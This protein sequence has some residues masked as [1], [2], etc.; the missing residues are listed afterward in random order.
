MARR[1]P[2]SSPASPK[3]LGPD[4]DFRPGSYW[5]GDSLR[6]AILGNIQGEARRRLLEQAL[7]AGD[8]DFPPEGLLRPI[9]EPGLRDLLGKIHPNFMGG[10]YLPDYLPEEVEIAR[11]AMNSTTGD[12][13]SIRANQEEDGLLHY[14]VVDEY[15]REFRLPLEVSDLPLSTGQMI[16]L[17]DGAE[18][19]DTGLILPFLEVNCEYDDAE[20]LRDFIWVSSDF[21]PD[22]AGHY[23]RV[24]DAFLDSKVH[25]AEEESE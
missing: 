12:V 17:I 5:P 10:E 7:E 19:D 24:T 13:I 3:Q 9:L 23:R 16:Q 21:Y 25:L 22:L 15:A 2:L 6:L 8:G 18:W 20:R 4:L 11:V 1:V 14:R